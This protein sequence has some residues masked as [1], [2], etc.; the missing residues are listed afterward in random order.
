M[1]HELE[2]FM[3]VKEIIKHQLKLAPLADQMVKFKS[4]PETKH[5][6]GPK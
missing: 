3:R 4:E 6:I 1:D 2:L 5:F